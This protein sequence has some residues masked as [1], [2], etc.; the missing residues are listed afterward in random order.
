[1]KNL[2]Q[3]INYY[4]KTPL[5]SFIFFSGLAVAIIFLNL[6]IIGG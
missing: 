5:L 1:M 4:T 2:F 6:Y 3:W